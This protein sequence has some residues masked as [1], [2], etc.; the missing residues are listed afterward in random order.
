[1]LKSWPGVFACSC[2]H[3]LANAMLVTGSGPPYDITPARWRSQAYRSREAPSS[4]YDDTAA[5][6]AASHDR[7]YTAQG[8]PTCRY[9][10]FSNHHLLT[11][12]ML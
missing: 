5:K 11:S 12:A 6:A 1:M 4:I 9:P 10:P 3:C 8:P 7:V 2:S